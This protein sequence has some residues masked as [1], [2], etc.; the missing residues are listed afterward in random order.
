MKCSNC[1]M[2]NI[3]NDAVHCPNCGASLISPSNWSGQ[4]SEPQPQYQQQPPQ[5]PPQQ[6]YQQ[7]MPQ[8]QPAPAKK[9]FVATVKNVG[10]TEVLFLFSGFLLVLAGFGGLSALR[11]NYMGVQYPLLG[12]IALLAGLFIL[13]SVIMPNILKS[14]DNMLGFILLGI[15]ALFFIWGM[16][17]LFAGNVGWYGAEIVAASLAG[18]A[19][20]ALKMGFI[21]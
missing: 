14:L 15:S 13:A 11:N 19:G 1:G 20:A 6:Q 4:P 18:L 17:A 9:Q 2:D 12:F 16:A 7:P 21:K 10:M 5:G 8:Y 3:V